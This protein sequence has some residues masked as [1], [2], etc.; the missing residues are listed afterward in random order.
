MKKLAFDH[1]E[2]PGAESNIVYLANFVYIRQ[3]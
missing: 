1:I 3:E 2:R